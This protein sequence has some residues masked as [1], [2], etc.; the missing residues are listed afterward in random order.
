MKP[1]ACAILLALAAAPALADTAPTV[2][3]RQPA[4]AVAAPL[5][6]AQPEAVRREL[7][8]TP[9]DDLN[10]RC[11]GFFTALGQANRLRKET[12]ALLD[13]DRAVDRLQAALV[14]EAVAAVGEGY[15][16][17][18]RLALAKDTVKGLVPKTRDQVA[19]FVN[20][21][22]K[23]EAADAQTLANQEAVCRAV[24]ER[25]A[26]RAASE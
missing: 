2:P 8:A 22:R 12:T 23:P 5:P 11:Q 10:L 15:S 13:P 21:L 25:V 1:L 14:A 9:P 24:L 6:P 4:P 3:V 18:Q 20:L 16:L 19:R 26:G 17:K 7:E